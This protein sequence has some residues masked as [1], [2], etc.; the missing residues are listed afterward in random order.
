[1]SKDFFPTVEVPEPPSEADKKRKLIRELDAEYEEL[2]DLA[3]RLLSK[4][5]I[6]KQVDF[7]ELD[8]LQQRVSLFYEK[9]QG[10]MLF[11]ILQLM[12][13][14]TRYHHYH[15]V[16]VALVNIIIGRLLGLNEL[17]IECLT[18]IG[19]TMDIGML[20]LPSSILKG[21]TI[22]E[23]QRAMIRKHPEY[24]VDILRRSGFNHPTML[25][26]IVCHHE[27]YDGS[28]YPQGL[29]GDS[30]PLEA[31]ITTV[32]D[33]FDAASARKKYRPNQSPFSILEELK[34][35]EDGK[36]DPQI[37]HTAALGLGEMLIGRWVVLSDR[38]VGKVVAVY[39]EDLSHP[40]VVVVGRRVHCGPHLHPV[41]LCGYIPLF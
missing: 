31:R 32:A 6:T 24:T 41:S 9:A 35:N 21:G 3:D 16:N 19:L 26:A 18:E 10:S 37:A 15:A 20:L 33:T 39:P 11:E 1:M 23:V 36:M 30:I 38:S 22:N 12:R 34:V 28:G 29:C 40:D 7:F 25:D 4:A 2:A 5:Q 8:F 17:Q 27:R 14:G 13:F